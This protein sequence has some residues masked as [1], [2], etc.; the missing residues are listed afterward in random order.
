MYDFDVQ[1]ASK[2]DAYHRINALKQSYDITI[3]WSGK[4]FC[5]LELEWNYV[6]GY[7]DISMR[8]F[9]IKTLQRLQHFFLSK[10]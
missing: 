8:N 7:V 5:G 6:Q 10:P 4:I 1:Y 9:V 2:H 3:D